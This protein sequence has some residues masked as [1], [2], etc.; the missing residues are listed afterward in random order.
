MLGVQVGEVEGAR[1]GVLLGTCGHQTSEGLRNTQDW[2]LQKGGTLTL[3]GVVLGPRVGTSEGVPDGHWLG[4]R[5]GR[6]VGA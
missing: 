3:D 5:L 1:E 4:A 2:R 6:L